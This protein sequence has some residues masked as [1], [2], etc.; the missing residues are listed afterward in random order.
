MAS[1][2]W[3]RPDLYDIDFAAWC[4]REA[5]LAR[6]GEAAQLDLAHIA[7]ELESL[8]N[9]DRREIRHCLTRLLTGLLKYR[10]QPEERTGHWLVAIAEERR[11]ILFVLEDSPSLAA[12]PAEVLRDCYVE[13]RAAAASETSLPLEAFPAACPF[14]AERAVD[15]GFLPE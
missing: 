6:A 4:D 15:R 3:T 9:A 13:A 11:R 1:P 5:A 14:T 8:G 12:Y 2:D 10:F 7:E